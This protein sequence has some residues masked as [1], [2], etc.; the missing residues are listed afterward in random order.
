MNSDRSGNNKG[1]ML[2][3]GLVSVV[4]AGLYVGNQYPFDDKELT[5]TIALAQRYQ[6]AQIGASDVVLGD[7]TIARFMQT[8]AF[9]MIVENPQLAR[10]F[11]DERFLHLATDERF[12]NMVA[13]E[14]FRN[15]AADARFHNLMADE[16]F[17]AAL[18]ADERFKSA[19]PQTS[20]SE[21]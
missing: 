12:R 19:W 17:K 2:A 15:L 9:Q 4:A 1:W 21:T 14:R 20:D 13:D 11:G 8:D 3:T 10:V 7:E 6:A 5:G 16:R 18:A